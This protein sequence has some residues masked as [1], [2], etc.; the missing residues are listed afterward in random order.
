MP[1]FLIQ[2]SF[3]QRDEAEMGAI[4]Q[5]TK[6]IIAESCPDIVW[7][8]SHIVS[9]E[10]GEITT[11]CVYAAPNEERVREHGALLGRH[12]ILEV[13]EIGAQVSPEDIPA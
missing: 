7:E 13:W 2:R 12:L 6:R 8:T 1:R 5:D 10:K 4:G 9:N 3:G 11:F